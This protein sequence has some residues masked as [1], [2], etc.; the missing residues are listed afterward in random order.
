MIVCIG[1]PVAGDVQPTSGSLQFITGLTSRSIT[2]SILPD[3]VPEITEV[4]IFIWPLLPQQLHG[5]C[6]AQILLV[7]LTTA[8]GGARIGEQSSARVS[9]L[10]NDKPY[11]IVSMELDEVVVTEEPGSDRVYY[12]PVTRR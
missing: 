1:S 10:P 7:N 9:V 12:V 4:R 11:G 8:S 2:I 5:C 6:V 3:D